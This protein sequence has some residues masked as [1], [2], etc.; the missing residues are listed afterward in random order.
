MIPESRQL[1]P[2]TG[3]LAG[4]FTGVISLTHRCGNSALSSNDKL[5]PG[6]DPRY[7]PTRMTNILGSQSH[8]GIRLEDLSPSRRTQDN[9]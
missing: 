2:R 9:S 4:A 8:G 1:W 5:L 3:C 6:P 7:D